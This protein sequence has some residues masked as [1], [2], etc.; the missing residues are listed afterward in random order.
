MAKLSDKKRS[1]LPKKDFAGPNRSF[2]V[3]DKI[4]AEKALQLAPRAEHAGTISHSTEARIE[5]KARKRLDGRE[6]HEKMHDYLA[7]KFIQ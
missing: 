7:K 1:E 4:H 5:S 2:P 6:Y 3:N